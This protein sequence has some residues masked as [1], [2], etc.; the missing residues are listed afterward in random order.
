MAWGYLLG[1]WVNLP[2]SRLLV[3]SFLPTQEAPV[4]LNP[5]EMHLNVLPKRPLK[6][7]L[8]FQFRCTAVH[9]AAS[10][11]FI[12]DV[13]SISPSISNMHYMHYVATLWALKLN[14]KYIHQILFLRLPTSPLYIVMYRFSAVV[15]FA[16]YTYSKDKTTE[17]GVSVQE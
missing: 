1:C 10:A 17:R 3:I 7:R 9:F 16:F 12:P 2:P 8:V 11:N 14:T 4:K 15:H 5:Y 13:T 6:I